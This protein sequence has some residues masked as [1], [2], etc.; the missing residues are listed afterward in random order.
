MRP[1]VIADCAD[2]RYGLA[3]IFVFIAHKH[4]EFSHDFIKYNFCQF[5]AP[6]KCPR[7]PV[8]TPLVLLHD[9]LKKTYLPDQFPNLFT[10]A[11]PQKKDVK[12]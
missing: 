9:F 7:T 2:A 3:L 4:T 10:Y 6:S 8:A 5:A 12:Y 11:K 1:N